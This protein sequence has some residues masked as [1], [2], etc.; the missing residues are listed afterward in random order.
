MGGTK[1][2][3]RFNP[4]I[5]PRL[6]LHQVYTI[7]MSWVSKNQLFQKGR[8]I[9]LQIDH[10]AVPRPKGG[11]WTIHL[12]LPEVKGFLL[13]I[14]SIP[15]LTRLC[16]SFNV[17]W[18]HLL[19]YRKWKSANSMNIFSIDCDSAFWDLRFRALSSKCLDL[20]LQPLSNVLSGR[21]LIRLPENK[22]T[23]LCFQHQ[24]NKPQRI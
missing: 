11:K 1:S 3:A 20:Q 22:V 6:Q 2:A 16:K 9:L 18:L 17:K 12:K 7:V 5:R 21:D 10:R 15:G 14:T 24:S 8:W 23:T 4:S 13:I 19:H